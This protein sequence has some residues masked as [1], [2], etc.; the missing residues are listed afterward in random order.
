ML[1]RQRIWNVI[2]DRHTV[3]AHQDPIDMEPVNEQQKSVWERNH[4]IIEMCKHGKYTYVGSR[5]F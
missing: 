4:L 3:E 2:Q 1:Y 5:F